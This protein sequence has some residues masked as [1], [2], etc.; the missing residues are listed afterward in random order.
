MNVKLRLISL[1]V[2]IALMA[3]SSSVKAQV[4]GIVFRDFNANGVKDN[5]TILNEVGMEGVTVSAYDDVGLITS[6]VSGQDGSWSMPS[7]TTF[8]VRIEFSEDID[9]VFSSIAGGTSVQFVTASSSNIDFGVNNPSD[10]YTVD[11][12]LITNQFIFGEQVDLTVGENRDSTILIRFNNVDGSTNTGDP[13]AVSSPAWTAIA[14]AKDIGSVWGLSYS[15]LNK[16]IYVSS[17]LKRHTGFGPSGPGAIYQI[18]EAGDISTLVDYGSAFGTDPHPA[19]TDECVDAAD[20][21][22]GNAECWLYDIKPNSG[23]T[24][25]S[26]LSSQTYD[27]VSKMSFGDLDINARGDTLYAMNLLSKSLYVI[28]LSNPTSPTIVAV[29]NP[30]CSGTGNDY[31]P[32]AIGVQDDKIYAGVV[33]EGTNI[34]D[35]SDLFAYVYVYE[36]GA[37]NTT[38]VLTIDLSTFWEWKGWPDASDWSSLSDQEKQRQA[39]LSDIEFDELNNMIISFRDRNTDLVGYEARPP[40]GNLSGTFSAINASYLLKACWNGTDWDIENNGSCGGITSGGDNFGD[41]PGGGEFYWGQNQFNNTTGTGIK[42]KGTPFGGSA[43]QMGS[44]WVAITALNPINNSSE[45]SDGGIRWLFNNSTTLI[46]YQGVSGVPEAGT[47]YKS[48]RIYDGS[49]DPALFAKAAGLGD[50]EYLGESAPLEIGNR[51]WEDTNGDGI[52]DPSE[53]TLDGVTVELYD[54]TN[55]G[56]L[57]GTATTANGG[58]YY[59]G[60]LANTNMTSGTLRY[61]NDYEIRIALSSADAASANNLVAISP[62][63]TGNGINDSDGTL[64]GS[65]S[66]K[67]FSTGSAGENNHT[68]DFGFIAAV[69]NLTDAGVMTMCNDEGTGTTS[70]DTFTVS[71][72]PTG[73]DL[74]TTYSVSGD[75]TAA[76]IPYGSA[77]QVG[78]TFLISGGDLTI[79]ITDDATG[80]C[81]LVDV[82][83]PAPAPCS[84]CSLTDAG[85]MTTCNDEGTGDPSDDTFTVTLNPTGSGIGGSYSVSGDITASNIAYGSA[86]AVGGSFLISGGDLTITITD[87]ATGTCTLVDVLVAAPAPCSTC[88]LLD[89]GISAVYDNKGTTDTGDDTWVIFTNPN[90]SGTAATYTV[91]GDVSASN[92]AYG[93]VQQVGEVPASQAMATITITDDGDSNCQLSDVIFNFN[94]NDACDLVLNPTTTCDDAGTPTDPSDDTFTISLNPTG[95][96]LGTTYSISG[97]ITQANVAYGSTQQIGTSYLITDGAKSIT[98]TDDANTLCRIDEV[99]S[100]PLACSSTC[101]QVDPVQIC[102]DGVDSVTLEAEAGLTNVVWYNSSDVQVGTGS[103][104]VVTSATPGMEDGS[105]SYYYTADNGGGCNGSA[106]CPAAIETI[107]CCPAPQCLSVTV[108]KN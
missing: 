56:T 13:S 78:G 18:T 101:P 63:D 35:A 33:C 3:H 11:P 32:F 84:T 87:D 70:D 20:S 107:N 23:S 42:H 31:H 17:Y 62:T 46:D 102:N 66:I 71:L 14:S 79:T 74:G 103:Q 50:L 28:P 52:Q 53:P 68:Y 106:C 85:V 98:L 108:T 104:L 21:S 34:N 58:Q 22:V 29:P 26:S 27:L 57:V 30:G 41:G 67:S 2:L 83:V 59:F 4:S 105:D 64:S 39:I 36:N 86:Q 96:G 89:G 76:N 38:P 43:Y 65:N 91:S 51:V 10:Y 61:N 75:I 40:L 88:N 9:A 80:T 19:P 49:G 48:Y 90:G 60:G 69:C 73:T 45:V 25:I 12:D 93:S 97:D 92:V 99:I 95:T 81:T 8:P 54:M 82:V 7:V 37:F 6:V 15:T 100:A 1:F 77:Q 5:T 47:T 55:G 72:N 44:P 94:S 24:D 16:T